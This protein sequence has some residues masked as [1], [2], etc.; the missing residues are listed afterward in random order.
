MRRDAPACRHLLC[1][2]GLAAHLRDAGRHGIDVMRHDD[3]GLLL[4]VVHRFDGGRA[5]KRSGRG[6]GHGVR[7]VE[8]CTR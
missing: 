3:L 7:S 5:G 1:K 2:E 6:A 8:E 4:R